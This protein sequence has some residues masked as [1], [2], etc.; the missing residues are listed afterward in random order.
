MKVIKSS[1]HFENIKLKRKS[2]KSLRSHKT[3]NILIEN[4]PEILHR[5][6]LHIEVESSGEHIG[7]RALSILTTSTAI[8]EKILF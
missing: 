7:K 1:K 6:A 3:D 8:G 2:L 5:I 4:M